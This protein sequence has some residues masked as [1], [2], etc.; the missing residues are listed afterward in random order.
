MQNKNVY[1][2]TTIN[3]NYK[4]LG[5]QVPYDVDYNSPASHASHGGYGYD[6]LKEGQY[7]NTV[8]MA[9]P[10]NP[11]NYAQFQ[12]DISEVPYRQGGTVNPYEPQS[13][14]MYSYGKLPNDMTHPEPPKFDQNPEYP[15]DQRVKFNKL[16]YEFNRF[17]ES[18][19][20]DGLQIDSQP[21]IKEVEDKTEHQ[22]MESEADRDPD[23]RLRLSRSII[24]DV[25]LGGYAYPHVFK[26][27]PF[28]QQ[29][30]RNLIINP[31]PL[32]LTIGSA[33]R[34]RNKYPNP[35][36]YVIPF[37]AGDTDPICVPGRIYKNIY[38]IEL[39]SAVVPNKNDI[40][41]EPY[42]IL[43]IDEIEQT[44]DSP[45]IPCTKAFVKLRFDEG[46]SKF[47]SLDRSCAE[48]YIHYYYPKPLAS[49]SRMTI[50]LRKPDGTLFNF[51]TDNKPPKKV[52]KFVQNN[53]TFKIVTMI[54]DVNEVIGQRNV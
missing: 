38:S 52:N 32:Y 44:Y 14:E 13:N 42:L 34:N 45:S 17:A 7:R 37:V 28:W 36:E 12:S 3:N 47:I 39:M 15:I 20:Q 10:G 35:S 21:T 46:V 22:A 9:D 23:H 1:S 33:D 31:K 8:E 4:T 24:G 19:Y 26:D 2:Q 6:S 54:T 30:Q 5:R 16:D 29:P 51:G 48:P 40:L 43:Q 25:Q 53:F 50:S 18:S 27:G 41:D 49:L 11:N